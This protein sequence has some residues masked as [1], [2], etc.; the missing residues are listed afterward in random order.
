MADLVAPGEEAAVDDHAVELVDALVECRDNF[1]SGATSLLESGTAIVQRAA[2]SCLMDLLMVFPRAFAEKTVHPVF[3][4]LALVLEADCQ[5]R[6]YTYISETVLDNLPDSDAGKRKGSKHAG[7]AKK[8]GKDTEDDDAD[9]A[10]D[11]IA[12]LTLE[13]AI[14]TEDTDSKMDDAVE[15]RCVLSL[16]VLS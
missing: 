10:A 13:G 2:Y 12:E 1:V 4:K 7:K 11:A 15:V 5:D 6:I 3:H 9:A 16:R 8:R 14:E